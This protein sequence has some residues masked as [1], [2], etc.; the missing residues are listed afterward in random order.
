MCVCGQSGYVACRTQRNC[1]PMCTYQGRRYAHGEPILNREKCQLCHCFRGNINCSTDV[2]NIIAGCFVAKSYCRLEDKNY[3]INEVFTADDGCTIC[4]CRPGGFIVCSK[5]RC[6]RNFCVLGNKTLAVGD[7]VL[8]RQR[9]RFGQSRC[10]VC[11]C[12]PEAHLTCDRSHEKCTRLPTEG[13]C[14]YKNNVYFKPRRFLEAHGEGGCSQCQC[15]SNGVVACSAHKT[16]CPAE[17]RTC[18]YKD[19]T[20]VAGD[21][22]IE[23]D[24]KYW[25]R[26]PSSRPKTPSPT[27]IAVSHS[28]RAKLREALRRV[29]SHKKL[30]FPGDINKKSSNKPTFGL[31][32]C[33][34]CGCDEKGDVSCVDSQC[35]Y[36]TCEYG[37][38]T[39]YAGEKFQ[40]QNGCRA[41]VCSVDGKFRCMDRKCNVKLTQRSAASTCNHKGKTYHHNETFDLR[42]E[43]RC[44]T[45]TCAKW[46]KVQCKGTHCRSTSAESRYTCNYMFFGMFISTLKVCKLVEE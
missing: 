33:R 18:R 14:V 5:H 20:Y 28:F 6:H 7:S 26:K 27:S 9:A 3:R 46:G 11:T 38:K 2:S 22:F 1:E 24:Y 32:Y 41:C 37:D 15:N 10:A 45:C 42:E 12:L 13:V 30:R 8:V 17:I 29:G 4:F 40:V 21:Y 43:G 44:L 35:R 36:R 16:S 25:N 31:H 23:T 19:A 39:Y 34:L